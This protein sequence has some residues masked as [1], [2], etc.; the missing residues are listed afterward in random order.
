[1][2]IHYLQETWKNDFKTLEHYGEKQDM[3]MIHR[4]PMDYSK[5]IWTGSEW[6]P[7]ICL[8]LEALASFFSHFF[9]FSFI[10]V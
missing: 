3:L 10:E 1:M 2:I 7:R 6:N 5:W 4:L 9:L 8:S